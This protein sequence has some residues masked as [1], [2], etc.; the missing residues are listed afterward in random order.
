MAQQSEAGGWRDFAGWMFL[1]A[2][3]WNSISG[4]AALARKE[5]F[6]EA[7]L[8]YQHLQSTGWVWLLLGI[9]Q[10]IVGVLIIGGSKVGRWT[11]LILAV[12]G[13]TIWMFSIGAYPFWGFLVIT[14]ELLIIYGL[15]V[16]GEEFS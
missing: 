9:A 8:L 11:G 4:V 2:G 15:A 1:L 3:F 10:L 12:L 6:N 14:I 7:G 16:H 5:Y 13:A